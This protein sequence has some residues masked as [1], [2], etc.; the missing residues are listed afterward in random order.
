[1]AKRKKKR[2][3]KSSGY[4]IQARKEVSLA[5]LEGKVTLSDLGLKSPAAQERIIVED[6]VWFDDKGN[7]VNPNGVKRARRVCWLEV[8]YKRGEIS[9]RAFAAG[10][11]LQ[12]AFE[13]TMRGPDAIK[14]VQVDS[15]PKPDANI[16]VT[17]DRQS[18]YHAIA[19]HIPQNYRVF[20]DRVVIDNEPINVKGR[21]RERYA[22]HLSA[23]LEILAEAL[24]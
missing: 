21:A 10:D 14:A 7:R 3:K 6:A 4:R 22:Q 23:G 8:Y 5:G 24:D 1:M 9:K 17:I 18:K 20:I 12:K 19:K 16:S 13:A 15:T 2:I 11:S